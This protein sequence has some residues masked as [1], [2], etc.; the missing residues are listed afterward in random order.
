[1]HT[2]R[3]IDD[4]T[5]VRAH[6]AGTDR[7]I[8]GLPRGAGMVQ[9]RIVARRIRP[10][11]CFAHDVLCETRLCGDLADHAQGRDDG[12]HVVFRRKIICVD[13]G[14]RAGLGAANMHRALRL[15]PQHVAADRESRVRVQPHALGNRART[16]ASAVVAA[17]HRQLVQLHL[18]IGAR[19]F[20]TAARDRHG[21]SRRGGHQPATQK[22]PARAHFRF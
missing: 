17:G 12:T 7:M 13:F 22:Q 15:R 3:R 14:R 9:Q 8:R 21:C 6:A 18:D 4:G 1:M 11:S 2:Q 5:R 20:R 16:L 19:Q 10:R